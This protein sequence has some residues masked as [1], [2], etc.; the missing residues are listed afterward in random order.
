MLPLKHLSIASSQSP[1]SSKLTGL[2]QINEYTGT[3][4]TQGIIPAVN[5]QSS[6]SSAAL[7]A[8]PGSNNKEQL[9]RQNIGEKLQYKKNSRNYK[10]KGKLQKDG[11]A[12]V[13]TTG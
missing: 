3:M 6:Q 10:L 1:Q 12:G 9:L 5:L 13:I 4:S 7:I 2:K 11:G 8:G